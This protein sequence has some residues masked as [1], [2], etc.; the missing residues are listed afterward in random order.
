MNEVGARHR[1][2]P[3]GIIGEY[4]LAH[5]SRFRPVRLPNGTPEIFTS[6][7]DAVIGAYRAIIAHIYPELRGQRGVGARAA[8]EALFG[9]RGARE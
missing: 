2:T 7:K 9:K 3:H 6:D 8:A 5:W 1:E 4:R